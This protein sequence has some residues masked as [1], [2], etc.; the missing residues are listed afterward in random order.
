MKAF[1]KQQQQLLKGTL[2]GTKI[3]W[4]QSNS[5]GNFDWG[6]P[7]GSY[8]VVWF[9]AT[10]L[11]LLPGSVLPLN[12]WIHS[13]SPFNTLS[14][15]IFLKNCCLRGTGIRLSAIYIYIYAHVTLQTTLW[16]WLH[17]LEE[18]DFQRD[19][20]T[21]QHPTD[22]KLPFGS[23]HLN[24]EYSSLCTRLC[25][26]PS[27]S[28]MCAPECIG[29][30][31]FIFCVL[32]SFDILKEIIFGTGESLSFL[33]LARSQTARTQWEHAFDDVGWPI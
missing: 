9:G 21:Y 20:V 11:P 19:E 2:L 14:S 7:A 1:K 3:F 28:L 24:P 17:C 32:Q 6:L 16:V 33:G 30:L 23:G 29:C 18:G 10:F 26:C 15:I 12:F 27:P 13:N 5:L 8:T 31:F 22:S 25:C 4:G